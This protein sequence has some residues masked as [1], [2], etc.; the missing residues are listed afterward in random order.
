LRGSMQGFDRQCA[1]RDANVET[2]VRMSATFPFVS[3][4]ARA[5]L[6]C[7]SAHLVDGGYYDNSGISALNT[8]LRQAVGKDRWECK[9]LKCPPLSI[10]E[11]LLLQILS[12]P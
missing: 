10:P 11:I 5:H 1:N 2:S 9:D 12:F 3:P 6:D 8:W 4:A 7:I